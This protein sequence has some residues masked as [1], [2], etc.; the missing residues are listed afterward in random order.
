MTVCDKLDTPEDCQ[1]IGNSI[2]DNY[3]RARAADD[4]VN[5]MITNI[6]Y[7][8]T[9]DLSISKSS[10]PFSDP[11][12]QKIDAK[13]W[14]TTEGNHIKSWYSKT[15]NQFNLKIVSGP[16]QGIHRYYN[17]DTL[18]QGQTGVE[19]FKKGHHGERRG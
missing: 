4:A 9:H 6:I 1:H 18:H 7:T 14:I 13:E 11:V 17:Y 16:D 3:D 19:N 15:Q 5:L 2:N 8:L 10:D 12:A